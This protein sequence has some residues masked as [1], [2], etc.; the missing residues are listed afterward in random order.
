MRTAAVRQA[1]RHRL[2][3][4]DADDG[5]QALADMVPLH[6]R[7]AVLDHLQTLACGARGAG[8]CGLQHVCRLA[9]GQVAALDLL[10]A[11]PAVKVERVEGRGV[12]KLQKNKRCPQQ[13]ASTHNKHT[14]LHTHAPAQ[15]ART[16][17]VDG[18][19][20]G[21]LQAV[22]VGAPVHCA[23]AV[24]KAHE[25]VAEGI[26]APLQGGVG[27]GRP[28]LSGMAAEQQWPAGM[29]L[30]DPTSVVSTT[31]VCGERAVLRDCWYSDLASSGAQPMLVAF[32]WSASLA[33]DREHGVMRHAIP[34]Q[35][36]G[37]QCASPAA[38]PPRER[39]P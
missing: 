38:P 8:L 7:V 28:G 29:L 27:G 5:G 13:R 31:A 21:C 39:R 10:Q 25:R 24:G 34:K 2:T 36:Q 14:Q 30:A 15:R 37:E 22:H 4:L 20:D 6:G 9:A 23:D 32:I 18:A 35:A 3:H 11:L 33:T 12:L 19:R 17:A 26:R 1:R 16:Q